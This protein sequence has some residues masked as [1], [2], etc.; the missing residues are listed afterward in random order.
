MWSHQDLNLGPP[1]YE[2]GATNQLS[3][4]TSFSADA[5]LQ[6]NILNQIKN[7]K[8][9]TK[10]K[11]IIFDLGNVLVDIDFQRTFDA[12]EAILGEKYINKLD[13]LFFDNFETGQFDNDFF[14]KSL[15][16][17]SNYPIST[18]QLVQAWNSMLIGL[19]IQRL[20]MLEQL[21]KDYNI[22]IL[23]NTNDIHIQWVKGY[24]NVVHPNE[25]FFE[26]FTKIYYSHEIH[27]RKPNPKI[28]QY[29]IEDQGLSLSDTIFIDDNEANVISARKMGIRTFLHDPTDDIAT[30]IHNYIKDGF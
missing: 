9:N 7:K 29:L 8:L 27:L 30:K 13:D 5:K 10:T 16:E 19:P 25:I 23:S 24:M 26:L 3:Y 21:K 28:Y 18:F 20:K 17:I 1:D 6:K 11:N 15:T 14:L 2:S 12:L 4:R 22:Y